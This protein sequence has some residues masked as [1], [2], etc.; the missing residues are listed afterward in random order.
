MRKQQKGTVIKTFCSLIAT[1]LAGAALWILPISVTGTATITVDDGIVAIA[2]DG[3]C[4]LREAIENA[5]DTTDGQPHLDC[6]AGNPEGTD[7]LELASSSTYT[8]TDGPFSADGANGLPSITSEIIING[9]DATIQRDP[10]FACPDPSNPEFRIFHVAGSGDLTLNDVTVSNGCAGTESD[11]GGIYNAGTLNIGGSTLSG[12]T[13]NFGGGINSTG[14]LSISD[15]V[16]SN[17]TAVNG[18]GGINST[19][20]L[21]ITNCTLSNNTTSYYGGGGIRKDG[22]TLN[23]NDSGLSNNSATYGGAIY[24]KSGTA[25]VDI[26]NSAIYSNTVAT[27]GGG[28]LNDRVLNIVNST[29]SANTADEGGGI[30]NEGTLDVSSSTFS[31]NT[32]T[33]GGG[34]RNALGTVAEARNTIVAGNSGGNCQ[35]E[36]TSNGYNIESANDCGLSATG[37][38]TNSTTINTTLGPL[39]DNGGPTFTHALLADSPAIDYIPEGTNGCGTEYTT[40]QRG[41][42]RPQDGD[43]NGTAACDIGAY[44]EETPPEPP[45]PTGTPTA[46]GTPTT[47]P[48]PTVT[49]TSTHTPTPTPTYVVDVDCDR[50]ELISAINTANGSGG[51]TTMDL[52]SG[53][54]YT[55]DTVDNITDGYNGLPSITSHITIHGHGATIER[56]S[57][58]G[59]PEFR[60][61]HVAEGADLTL[62]D[63][64]VTNG[65]VSGAYAYGGGIYNAGT[66]NISSSTLYGNTNEDDCGGAICNA[67][68]LNL[69]HST[70]SG[71]TATYGGGVCGGGTL[72]VNHSTFSGNTATYGGGIYGGTLN[73]SHS[74]FTTNTATSSGGGIYKSSGAA[75]V[76][77]SILAG[78]SPNNCYGTMM[79]QGYN[80]ESGMDC[81]F[82]DATDQQNA[83]ANLGPLQD[84]GGPTWTHALLAGSAATNHIPYQTSGCGDTYTTDQRGYSRPCPA[85]EEGACDIGAYEGSSL[86]GDLDCNCVV[87]VQD[88]MLVAAHWRCQSGDECYDDRYD[89]D[90]D[91]DIDVVDIMLVTKHW[92]DAC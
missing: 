86:V 15:S 36:I 3:L 9:N 21:V 71:N 78:N 61:F 81:G 90:G 54:T 65:Y 26:S 83:A 22:G 12:N 70:L 64:T 27:W 57:D 75:N 8:L 73:I 6:G 43:N 47:T 1:L 35:G 28:I 23:I 51:A 14:T 48:T 69:S 66:L 32:S 88:I 20:A 46:T 25:A 16:L 11:G 10:S 79:S 4:S 63:I 50:T 29:F 55:L 44:E 59:T 38:I 85:A 41:V 19:G 18:G 56:S 37:D 72:N 34:I 2:S 17:N 91:G 87:D 68:T 30:F 77:N 39:A 42:S 45:T 49:P 67:G 52:A 31:G 89:L 24:N 82:T 5:N 80:L 40:D 60:I 53:C 92:E 33:S 76:K 13:A 62:T 84:N 74:T 58:G 7:T